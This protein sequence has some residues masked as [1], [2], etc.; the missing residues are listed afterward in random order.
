[1]E[2]ARPPDCTAGDELLSR[3]AWSD[4]RAA[5]E[6]ALRDRESPEALE[7]LGLA[8]WWLDDADATFAARERAY[9][10]YR[11][12]GDARGAGRVATW[13]AW[14]YNA[15]RGESA[16]A[17]GWLRRARSLLE[18]VEPCSEQGWLCLREASVLLAAEPELARGRT[19]EA[20]ALGRRLGDVDLEM[21]ALALH[22][23]VR[24]SQGEVAEGMA[25]LE[26]ATAAATSGEVHDPNAIGF[27]CCYLIFACERTRDFDRAAQWCD[28]LTELAA[29]QGNRSLFSVCRSHY[30][31]VLTLRGAWQ[32]A[33]AELTPATEQLSA[34]RPG[35]PPEALARLGELRRRQERAD[36][37]GELFRRAEPQP[38]ARLGTASLALDRGAL[39]EAADDAT[40]VLDHFAGPR[41][42]EH[43][44]ALG[45]D[46]RTKLGVASRAAAAAKAARA[47]LL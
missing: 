20:I 14:D 29:G 25:E 16:V 41:R 27:A 22:G 33:E 26:E 4:A 38:L 39:E 28:R 23:L 17:N 11:H 35:I 6:A 12:G 1:M 2:T 37:A 47:G 40:S 43:V 34:L 13:L 9:R 30:A 19:Q 44:S 10:L 18:T 31:S 3:G 15:F 45:A 5:F 7:G 32:A 24:V 8:A 21:T 46:V 36:E 42:V